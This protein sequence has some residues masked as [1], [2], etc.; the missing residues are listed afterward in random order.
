MLNSDY[1][2]QRYKNKETGWDLGAPSTPLAKYIS[3][4]ENPFLEILIPGCGQAYEGELLWE[5][6][7]DNVYLLDYAESSKEAFLERVPDFPEE[8]FLVGDFFELEGQF[9]LI[10]E[11]TFFCALNPELRP[12]YAKKMAELLK[13]GGKLVG[14]L[15]NDKLND[16]HPPFGGSTLEYLGYFQPHF[17]EVKM[18]PCKNSIEPRMGRELFIKLTR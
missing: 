18:T 14:V 9:D 17:S 16:D 6:G 7:F 15:F 5:S 2:N 8:Q 4:L 13:P 12:A 10:L 1:W 11:Q 3:Q